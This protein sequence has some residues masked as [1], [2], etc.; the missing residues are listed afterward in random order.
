M[1][2][3]R[4]S[5][6]EPLQVLYVCAPCPALPRQRGEDPRLALWSAG[7]HLSEVRLCCCRRRLRVGLDGLRGLFQQKPF[8]DP[9]VIALPALPTRRTLIS[10]PAG[11]KV[12]LGNCTQQ[13]QAGLTQLRSALD[14][15]PKAGTDGYRQPIPELNSSTCSTP[16]RE[17]GSGAGEEIPQAELQMGSVR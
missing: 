10:P 12:L 2:G 11:E 3:S 1:G 17:G 4:L 14:R 16:W 9:V 15:Y 13:L 7:K 5:P 6:A 8:G